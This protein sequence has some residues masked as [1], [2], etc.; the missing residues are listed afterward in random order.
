MQKSE[1]DTGDRAASVTVPDLAHDL[2]LP[3]RRRVVCVKNAGPSQ[4]R[5]K[6]L[7]AVRHPKQTVNRFSG[8]CAAGA[9]WN[10]NPDK[11]W[12]LPKW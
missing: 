1:G 10:L 9:Q 11:V 2:L 4:A 8:G 12:V 5:S 3:V 6:H 7:P